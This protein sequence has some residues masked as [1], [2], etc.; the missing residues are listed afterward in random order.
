MTI[1][2]RNALSQNKC[3]VV[4]LIEELRPCYASSYKDI[5]LFDKG[6]F[7]KLKTIDCV[8]KELSAHWHLFDYDLLEDIIHLCDCKEATQIF[9]EFKSAIDPSIMKD[10]DLVLYCEEFT[11]PVFLRSQLR[12]KVKASTCN[13][14]VKTQVKAE[15]SKTYELNKYALYYREITKGCIELKFIASQKLLSYIQQRK[16]FGRDA[17]NFVALKIKSIQINNKRMTF[18]SEILDMVGILCT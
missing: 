16:I 11:K 6:T 15:L 5:P 9:E 10:M 13:D 14:D 12:V 2:V 3:N 4:D 17:A 18:P 8:W 7:E 1:E